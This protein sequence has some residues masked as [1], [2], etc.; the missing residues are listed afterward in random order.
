MPQSYGL[1]F[2]DV[3]AVLKALVVA[4]T[5]RP[6]QYLEGGLEV[7][8]S[9]ISGAIGESSMM[10]KLNKWIQFDC[11]PAF[12]SGSRPHLSLKTLWKWMQAEIKTF[13]YL[14]DSEDCSPTDDHK[15]KWWNPSLRGRISHENTLAQN[16]L[17]AFPG[18]KELGF[19]PSGTKTQLKNGEDVLIQMSAKAAEKVQS[20]PSYDNSSP[21]VK[22]RHRFC[23]NL[24]L[25]V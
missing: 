6:V 2:G 23:N 12:H 15:F 1:K 25:P 18:S 19:R 8:Y 4:I 5:R 13:L 24:I 7:Y 22:I 21:T 9:I 3:N 17:A 11:P 16:D 10:E 20:L 14:P